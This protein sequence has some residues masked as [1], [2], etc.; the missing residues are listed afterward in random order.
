MYFVY[1]LVLGQQLQTQTTSILF[2][3]ALQIINIIRRHAQ[4]PTIIIVDDPTADNHQL[5]RFAQTLMRLV[6]LTE[7]R[8]LYLGLAIFEHPIVHAPTSRITTTPRLQY[9]CKPLGLATGL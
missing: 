3:G 4:A 8:H 1:F 5:I 9:P 2:A 7:N 6:D